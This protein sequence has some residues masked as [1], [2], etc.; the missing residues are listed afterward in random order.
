MTRTPG[1]PEEEHPPAI[2]PAAVAVALLDALPVGEP[3]TLAVILDAARLAALTVALRATAGN[4]VHAARL[5]ATS[6]RTAC[7]T[8]RP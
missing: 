3:L 2:T 8:P 6:H 7:R 1:A 5:L 4:R